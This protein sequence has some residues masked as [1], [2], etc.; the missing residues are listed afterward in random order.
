MPNGVRRSGELERGGLNHNDTGYRKL[1]SDIQESFLVGEIVRDSGGRAVD[2]VY[3]EVN[4]AFTR[5]TGR[6]RQSVLGRR[7]SEVIPG[8]PR[9][10]VERYGSVAET[11]KPA[12]FDVEIPALDHR[13]YEVRAHPLGGER[14]A[15]LFLEITE[16]KQFEKALKESKASLSMIVDSV[17]QMIWSTRPDGYH[18]FF[19]RRW[20]EYTGAAPGTTDGDAWAALFHPDDRAR[21]FRRWHRSLATGEPYEVEY[22]LRH[23]SGAY[24][25]VLGR[26][27]PVRNKAGEIIRWMGTCT[28]IDELRRIQDAL[29]ES[30]QRFRSLAESLPQLVWMADSRGWVYWYNRRW[31]EYTGTTLEEM[32]G[33]GWRKVHH[34]DHVERVVERIQHAWD[35]GEPWEDVFPLRGADGH[36]RWFLSRAI[37]MKDS[38]NRVIRWVGTNTD[39]TEKQNL[40]QLQKTLIHE[41][42]HRVKNS[43]ALVSSLLTVQARALTG[44][45]RE[46]LKDASARVHAIAGVHDQLWRQ[47]G[48]REV[49]LSPFIQNLTAAIATSAPRHKTVVEAE[50]AVVSADLAIPIGLFLNELLT[51]AYKYAYPVGGE[52]EVRVQGMRIDGDRYRLEVTD[53]GKGLPAGFD[54]ETARHSLGMRII[55]SLSEQLGGKLK[56]GT[57]RPGTQF[58][59]IFPLRTK[60]A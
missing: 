8:F 9:S 11:G 32:R 21:A 40:E 4:D 55:A 34:P 5:Q 60:H 18:D 15:V 24:R 16:R 29:R 43:L 1:F 27:H 51:N 30:E 33:W 10:L 17:D 39:I 41:I 2:F 58:A 42:S 19:N 56:V 53:Y 35:A 38:E 31:Y 50:P 45:P 46:A 59:L 25:W 44:A 36:Y 49:D 26:G 37:P 20:Y 28:D 6:S 48:T 3:L 57:M 54:I 13:S 47:A 14:F 52:G 23:R 22:R 7:V 12:A